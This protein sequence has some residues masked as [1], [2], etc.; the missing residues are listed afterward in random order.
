MDTGGRGAHNAFLA[1][2]VEQS[3][4]G[5]LINLLIVFWTYRALNRL[6]AMDRVRL[7][8]NLGV[9]RTFLGA[10]ITGAFVSGKFVNIL[11]VQDQFCCLVLHAA[12]WNFSQQAVMDGGC[13]EACAVASDKHSRSRRIPATASLDLVG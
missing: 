11:L 10:A 6:E 8:T 9:Y 7:P 13:I 2:L 5:D 4:P 3:I 12:T 1:A